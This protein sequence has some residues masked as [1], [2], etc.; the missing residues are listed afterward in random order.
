MN[1]L[2]TVSEQAME[3]FYNQQEDI[4]E[5]SV[6]L[7]MS[8][9]EEIEPHGEKAKQIITSGYEFTLKMLAA[10]MEKGDSQLLDDQAIWAVRRLTHDDVSIRI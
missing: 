5:E 6:R 3:N 8:F 10:A 4:I 1:Q 9:H 2:K 7:S